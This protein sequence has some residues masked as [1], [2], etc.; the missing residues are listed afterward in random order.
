M[1]KIRQFYPLLFLGSLLVGCT[2][3]PI[4]PAGGLPMDPPVQDPGDQNL[5]APT[6]ISFQHQ[7]LPLMVSS[8]AYSGCHDAITA[9]DGIV[10]DSYQNIIKE[11]DPRNPNNS[12]LYES[13]VETDPDDIMPPPP[14]PQLTS[15]QIS[16]VRDWISQGAK[17]TDCG[18]AC[19]PA[20]ASFS[21]DIL[22]TIQNYCLGCHNASRA[23]GNV[24][25]ADYAQIL[26]YVNDGSLLGTI[27]Q[28]TFYPVMPPS[29]SILSDCRI[30]QIE[31]WISEGALDN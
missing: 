13:I 16:M 21:A 5:C 9:E 26:K 23:D 17:E 31:K 19:D 25:L 3:D 2:T 10:L 11:V 24:S 27:K 8:C 1:M 4:I 30:L 22:P 7:I 28:E 14:A 20:L 6:I 15:Q 12:E 18:T 29:G